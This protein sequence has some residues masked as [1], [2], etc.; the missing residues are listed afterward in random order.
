M[1]VRMQNSLSSREILT[2]QDPKAL[3]IK[4]WKMQRTITQSFVMACCL[5]VFL[6][7]CTTKS[8]YDH[9]QA[10]LQS[11]DQQLRQLQPNMADSWAQTQTMRKEID[12]L[13]AQM[14]ELR[15]AGGTRGVVDRLN[16]HNEA[17]RQVEKNLSLNF[18]LDAPIMAGTG[19]YTN[20]SANTPMVP[21]RPPMPPQA[22]TPPAG[23]QS[24]AAALY[25]QGV[26]AF[27][28]RNYSAAQ[29]AFVDFTRKYPS[30]AQVGNAWYFI[31]ESNF[32][33]NKFNDAA[34]AYD[35]VITGYPRSSR[36]PNAYLKQ[37]ISFS[38][39][40][41]KAA[42]TARMQELMRKYPNSGEANRAKSFL[43]TN[44]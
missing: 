18:N 32:Q 39:L 11:Q 17:L 40:G 4:R 34:L 35:K 26:S 30:N 15:L 22:S 24:G 5:L 36:A 43:Q 23:P 25:N 16:K 14:N 41:Q 20:P 33:M 10:R 9:L 2:F 44:K 3:Q 19:Q 38:K 6:G 13:K 7:G 1:C 8:D 27:N 31:G 28:S 12:V 37:A 42:A 29:A 21:S